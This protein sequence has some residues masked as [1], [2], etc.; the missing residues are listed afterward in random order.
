MVHTVTLAVLRGK[1][2]LKNVQ[3]KRNPADMKPCH[4]IGIVNLS[5]RAVLSPGGEGDFNLPCLHRNNSAV[6]TSASAYGDKK[7]QQLLVCRVCLTPT[8][9]GTCCVSC[10]TAGVTLSLGSLS[11]SKSFLL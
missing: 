2:L 10:S 7:T 5:T 3:Q 11:L 6:P 9:T 4:F 1:S 8:L